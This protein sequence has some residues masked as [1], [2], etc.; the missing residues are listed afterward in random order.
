MM[1]HS[2]FKNC[3]MCGSSAIRLDEVDNFGSGEADSLLLAECPRCD[4]RWTQPI[5]RSSQSGAPVRLDPV[6]REISS[7]V[8]S[9]A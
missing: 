7:E 2:S 3:K 9:A 5:F 4:A 1:S 6:R 8:A